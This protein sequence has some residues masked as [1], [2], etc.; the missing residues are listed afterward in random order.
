MA[1]ISLSAH[2]AR[3]HGELMARTAGR[4]LGF[5]ADQDLVDHFVEI[6]QR[7]ERE[8]DLDRIED[9]RLR[10]IGI[11]RELNYQDG[12]VTY[13]APRGALIAEGIIGPD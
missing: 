2:R 3:K 5:T 10:D 9:A 1:T 11:V 13:R 12:I 8:S 7:A 6:F 4:L